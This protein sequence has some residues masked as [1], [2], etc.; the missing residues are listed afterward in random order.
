MI[1]TEITETVAA[2]NNQYKMNQLKRQ[3]P[4]AK[5]LLVKYLLILEYR[6]KFQLPIIFLPSFIIS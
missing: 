2:A 6:T 5:F 3:W 1:F 4:D